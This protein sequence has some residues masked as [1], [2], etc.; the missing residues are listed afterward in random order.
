MCLL[1]SM[2]NAHAQ[3]P[4]PLQSNG[5]PFMGD[6][7]GTW[8]AREIGMQVIALGNGAYTANVLAEFDT[9]N[10]P[11][12]ILNGTRNGD[13][14]AFRG[15]RADLRWQGDM[16]AGE[17]T[18]STSGSRSEQFS[19]KPIQRLSPTLGAEPPEGAVVLFDG[20]SLDS[21]VHPAP[22][23]RVLDLGKLFQGDH[24]VAYLRTQV[25]SS[26]NQRLRLELGSDDGV[27]AWLNGQLVHANNANRG[28]SPGQD[29]VEVDITTGWNTLLLK[30]TQAQG[31]FGASA[32]FAALNG[33]KATGLYA[34]RG[35]ELQKTN[36]LRNGIA[37]DDQHGAIL[38][39][40]VTGPFTKNGLQGKEL[41]DNS[42][43][44][45]TAND[46]SDWKWIMHDSID[47]QTCRW[48][49]LPDG[50]MEVTQG[51]I[52]SKQRFTDIQLHVEFRTPFMPDARGQSR[53]NSGVYLQGRYEVQVLDS[54]GLK[55]EWNECGGIYQI[56]VPRVNMAAPP[57]QWQ[58]YD[59]TYHAPRFNANGAKTKDATITVLHN[60]VT[61]HE[62]VA[63]P[64]PTA[65][66]I[67]G[68]VG[69]PGGIH[70]QDHGNP[71]QFRNIWAV[72]L[73]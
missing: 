3:T 60:G 46:D 51:G 65:A 52:V 40:Q 59:I 13:T 39:W 27:K 44:P 63:I 49:L 15:R 22:D 42:F 28:A 9:R 21:W 71:V 18:G 61:I 8:G 12:A 64:E 50:A 34:L 29:T 54:Y 37:L 45:E 53:G 19:L 30:I 32:Q 23:P 70:L 57:L 43:S 47:P 38:D 72:E 73:D 10:E 56:A 41:F 5:D 26:K 2:L 20:S 17:F 48:K 7:K 25:W 24:R 16:R 36:A 14:V 11:L 4:S 69:E 6:W 35:Q 67:G 68:D 31:G 62:N 1:G 66:H 58:T 55:G 33:G